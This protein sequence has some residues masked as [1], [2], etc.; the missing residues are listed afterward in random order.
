MCMFLSLSLTHSL[1]VC[2][3]VYCK[4]AKVVSSVDCLVVSY[5]ARNI[6]NCTIKYWKISHGNCKRY[7]QKIIAEHFNMP[8]LKKRAAQF[9]ATHDTIT[10]SFSTP[11]TCVYV[12]VCHHIFKTTI[13]IYFFMLLRVPASLTVL[14]FFFFYCIAICILLLLLL[15]FRFTTACMLENSYF[16]HNEMLSIDTLTFYEPWSFSHK[17]KW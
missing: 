1:C 3:S 12:C 7:E 15:K 16:Q 4:M 5:H 8:S 14:L 13:N 10:T 6:D 11:Y 9:Q 17:S 2:I